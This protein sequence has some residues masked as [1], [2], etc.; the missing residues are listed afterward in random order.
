MTDE[1]LNEIRA[2]AESA[3][4]MNPDEAYVYIGRF[5]KAL[6]QCLDMIA[7]RDAIIE[8]LRVLDIG[9]PVP[10]NGDEADY[11]AGIREGQDRARAFIRAV[12]TEAS[13]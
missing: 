4:K 13:H 2:L 8:K 11:V 7:E 1:L 9:R 12:L 10:R 5:A 3:L 6:M